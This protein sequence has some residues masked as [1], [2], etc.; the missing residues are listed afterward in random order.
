M[1]CHLT[2]RNISIGQDRM[3]TA[4]HP[5]LTTSLHPPHSASSQTSSISANFHKYDHVTFLPKFPALTP[6]RAQ[7]KG[8]AS[9]GSMFVSSRSSLCLVNLFPPS[10]RHV[11]VVAPSCLTL[12]DPMD[13]ST[14]GFPVL[15]YLLDFAQTHVQCISDVIQPSHPLLPSSPPALNLSQHQGL[16][17]WVGSSH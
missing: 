3:R 10:F 12:C 4:P 15:H 13:C 16:F 7:M 8:Q 1:S 2:S 9:K 17:Q 5:I 6:Q 14:L 11:A